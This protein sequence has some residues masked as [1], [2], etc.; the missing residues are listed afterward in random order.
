MR[1]INGV[2]VPRNFLSTNGKRN[3]DLLSIRS[4]IARNSARHTHEPV[5]HAM[6]VTHASVLCAESATRPNISR[7]GGAQLIGENW[8]AFGWLNVDLDESGAKKKELAFNDM[9]NHT[10]NLSMSICR[11]VSA[12]DIDMIATKVHRIQCLHSFAMT[13]K[14]IVIS[15]G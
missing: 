15:F 13:E 2:N 1:Q 14:F 7:V 5:R 8:L 11:P 10:G 9:G 6:E 4:V 3:R 12:N